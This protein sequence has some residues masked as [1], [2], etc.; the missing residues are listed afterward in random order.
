MDA[1]FGL[2]SIEGDLETEITVYWGDSSCDKDS[3]FIYSETEGDVFSEQERLDR[4]NRE[5]QRLTCTAKAS[6]YAVAAMCGAL[7]G[8]LSPIVNKAIKLGYGKDRT[9]KNSKGVDDEANVEEAE[10]TEKDKVLS[11]QLFRELAKECGEDIPEKGKR[12]SDRKNLLGL[13][14]SITEQFSEKK[15]FT[16]DL[17]SELPMMPVEINSKGNFVG[18]NKNSKIFSGILNWLFK[19]A[20]EED[21]Y[22]EDYVGRGRIS[23]ILSPLMTFVGGMRAFPCVRDRDFRERLYVSFKDYVSGSEGERLSSQLK[24][25]F[26]TDEKKGLLGGKYSAVILDE[27]LVRAVFFVKDFTRQMEE[28]YSL[29]LLDFSALMPQRDRTLERMTTVSLGVF[30]A[31]DV[32]RAAIR[33]AA[34]GGVLYLPK[35]LLDMVLKVNIAGIGR[36]VLTVKNDAEMLS[37][38]ESLRNERIRLCGEQLACRCTQAFYRQKQMWRSAEN[39]VSTLA[40]AVELSKRTVAFYVK[41]INEMAEDTEKI[42]EDLQRKKETQESFFGQ[43][44][45]LLKYE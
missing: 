11:V 10:E 16:S 38:S 4:V 35:F 34:G 15:E 33:S 23:R 20:C 8:R 37:L 7:A 29:S 25:I 9:G 45:D 42:K 6:D 39:A 30:T 21:G 3:D 13:I 40:E 26:P 5:L 36:F 32:S 43:L 18:E 27:L 1:F 24:E 14:L 12:L 41:A 2:K 31:I 19:I 28:N 17:P 22:R 44:S